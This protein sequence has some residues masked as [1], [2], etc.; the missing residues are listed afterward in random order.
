MVYMKSCES[1][2]E[3]MVSHQHNRKC[4][5]SNMLSCCLHRNNF[6]RRNILKEI[7]NLQRVYPASCTRHIAILLFLRDMS[8]RMFVINCNVGCLSIFMYKTY[9]VKTEKCFIN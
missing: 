5:E 2:N 6:R 8:F 3:M 7:D 4:L 9:T 1:R